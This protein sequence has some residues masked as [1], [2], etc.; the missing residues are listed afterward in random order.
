MTIDRVTTNLYICCKC[1]YQWT[2]RWNGNNGNGNVN[3]DQRALTTTILIPV[4]ATASLPRRCP[5]CKSE[6]WNQRYLDEEL[7]L[8]DRLQD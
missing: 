6:R 7:A 8:I 2:R 4:T 1:K 3:G 5:K